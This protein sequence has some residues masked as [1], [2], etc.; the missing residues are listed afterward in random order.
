[1]VDPGEAASIMSPMI[2]TPETTFAIQCESERAIPAAFPKLGLRAHKR[3]YDRLKECPPPGIGRDEIDAHFEGMPSR[4]WLNVTKGELLWGL[5]TIHAFF[6]KLAGWELAG[7]PVV[8]NLRHCPE[9]GF[10]RVGVCTWDR[11]GLLAKIAA[12]FSAL[13]VN[14]LQADVYTRS[15]NVVLDVF[16][17]SDLNHPHITDMDRLSHLVFLLEGALNDPPRFVSMWASQFHKSIEAIKGAAPTVEIDNECSLTYSVMRVE[18]SDRLGL[19]CDILE[20]LAGCGV[21]VAQALVHTE[22]TIARDIFYLTDIEGQK[23]TNPLWL[24]A[25]RKSVLE[26]I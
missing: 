14:I 23:I 11:P 12:T 16:Q 1:M 4:Y 22:S 5:E 9:R 8:A 7:A 2:D 10:T 13:R 21:N 25:I 18:A 15:D 17:V 24:S 3:L 6:G 20:G 19:L 26:A